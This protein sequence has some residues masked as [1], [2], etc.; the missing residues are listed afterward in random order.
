MYYSVG[1]LVVLQPQVATRTLEVDKSPND[2]L[3]LL[4]RA[5]LNDKE[6][7]VLEG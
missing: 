6:D 3:S 2:Q 1:H 7:I 4:N 5:I